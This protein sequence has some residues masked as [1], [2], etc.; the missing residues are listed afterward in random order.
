VRIELMDWP[1]AQAAA[2]RIRLEVFVHEQGVPLELEMDD[3]DAQSLHALATPAGSAVPVGTARLLPDG[4]IGRMA[5]LREFR[6]R[7]TGRALLD[8]LI[9]QAR[10]A[11][12]S[13]AIVNAQTYAIAFYERAGFAVSS[14]V[15]DEAGI[16]HAEMRRP[17]AT[18]AP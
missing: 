13:E 16:P 6:R 9:E 1:A 2:S 11:G 17:L 3:R 18:A 10:A 14:G 15:F 5:V 7:G 8:A 4:H 12:H